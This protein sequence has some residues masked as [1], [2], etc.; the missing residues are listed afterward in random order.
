MGLR[1]ER[2]RER[3]EEDGERRRRYR[4]TNGPFYNRSGKGKRTGL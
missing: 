3:K 2:E 4:K 1:E